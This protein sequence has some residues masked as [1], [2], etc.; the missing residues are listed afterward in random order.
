VQTRAADQSMSGN[1]GM[2]SGGDMP[3]DPAPHLDMAWVTVYEMF[4]AIR[5]AGASM[6][7][8][9]FIVACFIVASSRSDGKE[10]PGGS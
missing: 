8:A 9:A 6:L 5:S 3:P 2:G 1:A 10:K 7:E 4:A